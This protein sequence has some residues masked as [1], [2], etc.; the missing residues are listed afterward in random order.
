ME[1]E[2][3]GQGNTVPEN[4]NNIYYV[5]TRTSIVDSSTALVT[6]IR[7]KTILFEIHQ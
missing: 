7:Y 4:K 1:E 6:G 3:R 5:K 2:S